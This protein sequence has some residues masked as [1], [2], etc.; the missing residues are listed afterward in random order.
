MSRQ[1]ASGRWKECLWRKPSGECQRP[2]AELE[3]HE[4]SALCHTG[5]WPHP[6]VQ[7]QWSL[8]SL[9]SLEALGPR[10]HH[11]KVAPWA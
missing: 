9:A 10:D 3:R 2:W 8:R 11:V 5:A 1:A 4:W 6:L 7:P